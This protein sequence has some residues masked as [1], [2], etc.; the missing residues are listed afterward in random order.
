MERRDFLKG[1]VGALASAGALKAIPAHASKPERKGFII[2]DDGKIVGWKNANTRD[3]SEWA[4]DRTIHVENVPVEE[5]PFH[6]PFRG[7]VEINSRGDVAMLEPA[8]FPILGKP[9]FLHNSAMERAAR[10]Q[11]K[12]L[13]S[14]IRQ[15]QWA[16]DHGGKARCRGTR[17]T[18][19]HAKRSLR[20]LGGA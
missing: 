9:R 12:G 4:G 13:R 6:A 2:G 8:E 5:G 10:A 18:L 14:D 16:I 3:Q 19:A 11:C 1:V 15:L 17:A 7:Y 20:R